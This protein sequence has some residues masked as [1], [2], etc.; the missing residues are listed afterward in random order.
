M[1]FFQLTAQ[2]GWQ[3]VFAGWLRCGLGK[4]N[5]VPVHSSWL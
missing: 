5:Y 4:F 1:P 2:N 3:T